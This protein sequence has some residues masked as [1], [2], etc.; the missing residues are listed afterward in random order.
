VMIT[1]SK[2]RAQTTMLTMEKIHQNI[3]LKFDVIP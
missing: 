3:G 2:K 1:P